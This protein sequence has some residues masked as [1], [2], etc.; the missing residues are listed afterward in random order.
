[1]FLWRKRFGKYAV[2]LDWNRRCCAHRKTCW[3]NSMWKDEIVEEVRRIREEHAAKF[4]HDLKAI[5]EDAVKRQKLSGRKVVSFPPRR[6]KGYST[7]KSAV[8]KA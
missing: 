2:I 3:R 6:P 7:K 4:N 8:E 5:Y 1:M